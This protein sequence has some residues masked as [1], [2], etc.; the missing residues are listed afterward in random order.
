MSQLKKL[1]SGYLRLEINSQI[2]AQWNPA[3]TEWPT[4]DDCFQP[5]WSWDPI[6]K[7]VM[8]FEPTAPTG[9]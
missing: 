6:R 5:D 8:L 1:S 3:V 9:L 4:R 2:W 7:E